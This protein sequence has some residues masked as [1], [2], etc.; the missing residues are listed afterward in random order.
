MKYAVITYIFGENKELLREPLVIDKDIEYICITDQENLKSK[1]WKIL[2]DNIPEANCI[3]DKMV[4][5]KYNPFKYTDAE[6]ICVIDGSLEISKSLV[7]LFDQVKEKDIL[8]KIHPERYNLYDE[9]KAWIRL[10]NMS[11]FALNKFNVIANKC[12]I[13]LQKKFLIESCVIVYTRKKEILELCN[14]ELLYMKFLGDNGNL[15]LSNQCIL[16]FLIQQKNLRIGFIKG[17]DF[18][19]RYRHNSNILAKL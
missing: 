5:V 8:I 15:F 9:L 18:F 7:S 6:I 4:Y 2:V 11:E 16:T 12:S 1:T 13:D 10:R 19:K 17:K 14:E 3:R